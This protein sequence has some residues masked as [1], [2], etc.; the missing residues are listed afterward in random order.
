MR[1]DGWRDKAWAGLV[2]PGIAVRLMSEAPADA[3]E[4]VHD[5]PLSD[6]RPCSSP[7][8]SSP[9]GLLRGDHLTDAAS[10]DRPLT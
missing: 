5:P 10:G 1:G 3:N 7:A 9:L 8:S 6:G 4:P 2:A